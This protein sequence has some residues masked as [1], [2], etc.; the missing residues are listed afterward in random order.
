[1]TEISP[2]KKVDIDHPHHRRIA[3][4]DIQDAVA[5]YGESG[6]DL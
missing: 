2:E 4:L 5:A 3:I 1:V 6:M